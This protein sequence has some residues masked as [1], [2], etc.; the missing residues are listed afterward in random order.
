[1]LL[2]VGGG[3]STSLSTTKGTPTAYPLSTKSPEAA[4][5]SLKPKASVSG[6][7][8]PSASL[9]RSAPGASKFSSD[10]S[11]YI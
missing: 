4:N 1:M 7:G 3:S 11:T 9:Q 6:S 8:F 10:V 5:F 2:G